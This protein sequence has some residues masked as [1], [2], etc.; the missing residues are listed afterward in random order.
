MASETDQWVWAAME[1][2]LSAKEKQLRDLFV[3]E[4][5]VD[6][7]GVAAAQRCGFQIS[8]AKDYAIRFLNESYVRKKIKELEHSEA[9]VEA[10]N[11]KRV[12]AVL[13]RESQN[14]Y[15]TGSAR[16]AAAS[17]LAA[18]YGMDKPVEANL[19]HKHKG[20]VL[21]LPAIADLNDWEATAKASQ[22]KLMSDARN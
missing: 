21:L 3:N 13:V 6:Y 14:P 8:F 1:P 17:K 15:T 2:E 5:L 4:Y 19:N 20:G 7:D 10:Y 12:I 11:K 22:A 16:V 9:D 18:I